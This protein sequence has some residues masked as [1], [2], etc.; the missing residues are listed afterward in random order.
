MFF[1]KN[2]NITIKNLNKII[3]INKLKNLNKINN[4][5]YKIINIYNKI[6]NI[7]NDINLLKNIFINYNS[8]LEINLYKKKIFK[9]IYKLIILIFKKKYKYNAI[10]K[11]NQKNGGKDSYDWINILKN[12]YIKWAIINNFKYKIINNINKKSNIIEI[13]KKYSF[14][15]LYG[16]NGI[17]KLIRKSPFNN[18]NKIHTSLASIYIYPKKNIK[19]NYINNNELII[20]TFRSSGAGGQNINKVETGIRIKHIPTNISV[21]YTK[22]RSQFINK[23]YAIKLLNKKLY[24]F[25]LNKNKIYN[26]N[27]NNYIRNYIFN[28][29][30]L[31]KDFNTGYKTNNINNI[32]NGNINIL[33]Y[34]NIKNL[35]YNI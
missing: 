2:I 20:N 31:I 11:I 26:N 35:L 8:N 19:T 25:Y 10:I 6:L 13:K 23:K 17:H 12:M 18:K 4:K 22:N 5:Y 3:N 28:P 1:N 14:G 15:Y 34:K 16:E 32:I 24:N 30:K 29:Y 27:N 21:E 33:L 9:L 7:Y